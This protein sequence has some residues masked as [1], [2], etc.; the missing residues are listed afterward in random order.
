MGFS[1]GNTTWRQQWW[2]GVKSEWWGSKTRGEQQKWAV[3]LKKGGGGQKH[4]VG[5]EN[6]W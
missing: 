4:V 5:L 1:R 3:G 2:W 6:A